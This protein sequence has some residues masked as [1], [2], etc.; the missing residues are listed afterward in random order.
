[1]AKSSLDLRGGKSRNLELDFLRLVYA[2]QHHHQH[3]DEAHGYLAVLD[4]DAAQ[5]VNVWEKKYEAEAL[6]TCVLCQVPDDDLQALQ[7]EKASN[8]E[9]MIAGTHCRTT[10][11]RSEASVGRRVGE[12][13]LRDAILKAEPLVCE[14]TDTRQMPFGIHWDFY[15]TIKTEAGIV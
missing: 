13:A 2:V 7:R 12:Q 14:I 4:D 15:G 11:R 1:M 5:R 8:V 9:G 10:G 6:V 3:G